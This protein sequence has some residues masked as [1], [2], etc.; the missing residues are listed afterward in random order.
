MARRPRSAKLETR[1]SR[2]KLPVRKKPHFATVALGIALGYRRNQGAGSWVVR[3]AD[4]HGG[5]WTKAFA[6]AD[7]HED[8]DGEHVLTFWQ[9]QDKAR[10]LARGQEAEGAQPGSVADALDV[11]AGDLRSRGG[12]ATNVTRVR[13]HLTPT[14]LSKAVA[15]LSIRDLRRWRDALLDKGLAP[16]SV[17]R[18]ARAFKAA[19]ELAAKH[20]RRI[21][22]RDAWKVGL[23]GIPDAH[24]ARNVILP[25]EDVHRLIAAAYETGFAFGLLV[26]TL[27]STGARVSQVAR[28]EV[29]DLQANRREPRLMM[30]SS[31]KGRGVRR[32]VR[33][34]VP[35]PLGLAK[36]LIEA[37]GDRPGQA[38]LLLNFAGAA[39]D[40][41][42]SEHARPFAETVAL[43][44]LA[45]KVTAYAL[46]HSSIVRQL[47]KGVPIRVVAD[48]HD[49][50]VVM[51]ERT[52][53]KYIGEHSDAVVRRAL[54]DIEPPLAAASVVPLKG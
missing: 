24:R 3:A 16:A 27:A 12:G 37:A 38:P 43:A 22:N 39:W 5:N 40:H 23:A 54:L 53:S 42:H 51:I 29:E 50:S 13:R 19:L 30:P 2:L 10:Q 48:V 32:I 34:P 36:R 15:L 31:R 1:T 6:I 35:I 45:P 28:L 18:T 25:D 17:N 41:E 46:R 8:A 20:D 52:Y 33:K 26:E 14:L 7:D 47:L 11:Y 44:K 21:T 9:A 49:T 4:G